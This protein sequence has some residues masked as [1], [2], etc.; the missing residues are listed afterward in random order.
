MSDN[1]DT[2]DDVHDNYDNDEDDDDYLMCMLSANIA[3][4]IF[5]AVMHSIA[6]PLTVV[7]LC[8]NLSTCDAT[9]E[10]DYT[11]RPILVSNNSHL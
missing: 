11:K 8:C 3:I 10:L 9:Q 4:R 5:E 1:N 7:S 2:D 6:C